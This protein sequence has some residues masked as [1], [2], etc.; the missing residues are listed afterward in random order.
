MPSIKGKNKKGKVH[1][2]V[3]TIVGAALLAFAAIAD[4]LQALFKL[5]WF[6]AVLSI[7]AEALGWFLTGFCVMI[8]SVTFVGLGVNFIGGKKRAVIKTL[9]FFGMFVLEFVPLLN[10]APSLTIWALFTI[11]DSRKEDREKSEE[12]AKKQAGEDAKIQKVNVVRRRRLEELHAL[13][14]QAWG[15]PPTMRETLRNRLNADQTRKHVHVPQGVRPVASTNVNNVA[16]RPY[17]RD[18]STETQQRNS[19][20]LVDA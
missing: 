20:E 2:R 18:T 6:T 11:R 10:M 15:K 14:Q 8:L 5:M 1:Y 17:D 16:I 9:R 13:A 4:L 12:K 19:K 7:L 3:P